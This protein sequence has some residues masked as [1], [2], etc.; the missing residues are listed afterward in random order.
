MIVATGLH[1]K[2]FFFKKE[3]EVTLIMESDRNRQW[4]YIDAE[5]FSFEQLSS[6]IKHN[7]HED[8]EWLLE[9]FEIQFNDIKIKSK[10]SKEI[11]LRIIPYL[12]KCKTDKNDQ[13]RDFAQQS[14]DRILKRFPECKSLVNA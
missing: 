1:S 9:E 5:S 3:S 13:L 14:L 8:L 10:Q 12:I 6:E 4:E 2:D 7:Q 11:A